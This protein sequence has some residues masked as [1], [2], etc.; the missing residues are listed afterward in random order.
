MFVYRNQYEAKPTEESIKTSHSNTTQHKITIGTS[1]I[2]LRGVFYLF[3]IDVARKILIDQCNLHFYELIL[4]IGNATCKQCISFTLASVKIKNS[5]LYGGVEISVHRPKSIGFVQFSYSSFKTFYIINH[6]T[7]GLVSF[8]FDHCT[9]V[10]IRW[11]GIHLLHAS[12]VNI[13]NCQF[14]F[15][16]DAWCKETS[17]CINVRG[18][19][20]DKFTSNIHVLIKRIF[21][22]LCNFW[23][24]LTVHAENSV[25][26]GSAGNSGG[27]M[28]TCQEINLIMINCRMEMK[29]ISI[30]GLTGG[31]L[32]FRGR[33]YSM[34]GTNVTFDAS[35]ASMLASLMVI[36]AAK[37][38][39]SNVLLL[40]GKATSAIEKAMAAGLYV[41]HEYHCDNPCTGNEYTFE[42]GSMVLQGKSVLGNFSNLSLMSIRPNCNPCPIGANCT[43]NI[44]ALP[45]YWGYKDKSD[46]VM[47]IR[48]PNGYCCQNDEMC[49]G[50]DSCN[51]HRTGPLCAKC[52]GNWTESLFSPECLPIEYCPAGEIIALY[53]A[54]VVAYGLGLIAFSYV[55]DLGP[56]V[57][58]KIFETFKRKHKKREKQ[59]PIDTCEIEELEP[60][61]PS[62]TMCRSDRE[63][64]MKLKLLKGKQDSAK[65]IVAENSKLS[66]HKIQIEKDDDVMKYVQ[67]LFYYVQDAVLFKV[68][69]P[70]EGHQD[71]SIV[72]K[73][74]HF[75]PEVVTTLYTQVSSLCFHPGT[76]AVTKILFS[77]LFG[78]CVIVFIL[79]LY[80][81][82]KYFYH[83]K[84]KSLKMF[85]A[86]LVQ[87]FLLVVLFSYQNM[88]KGTFALVQCV[89]IENNTVLYVQG[90]IECHSY[91]QH[92]VT[93]YICLSIIPVFLVLSHAPFCVEDKE[94]SVRTFILGCLLP[95]PVILVYYMQIL[96]TRRKERLPL[97]LVPKIEVETSSFSEHNIIS[98]QYQTHDKKNEFLGNGAG[99]DTSRD[100]LGQVYSSPDSDTDIG[101]EYS[102]DFMRGNEESLPCAELDLKETTKKG[103]DTETNGTKNKFSDC[104]EAINHTLLKH[105]RPLKVCSFRF[106]WLGIHKLYRVSLVA[107]NT[108]ITDPLKKLCTMSLVL[109]IIATVNTFTKPYNDSNTNRVAI[110]SY[111]ANICIAFINLCKTML[112]T[113]GCQINCQLH[114][115]TA[116]WYLDK[117]ENVLLIY[118][119]LV[120]F[121]TALLYLAAQKCRNKE[122]D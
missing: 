113:Y 95:L 13:T 74:L 96:V 26:I 93:A 63:L 101:S 88:V 44:Q 77:S 89:Q 7:R 66:T 97:N 30:P 29:E 51:Q 79:F 34:S 37:I 104:R 86:R 21:F 118:V 32:D 120:L 54:C 43:K 92:F 73:I 55:K 45:N 38:D 47:M 106:T 15:R 46:R 119:P 82:Q 23:H 71:E 19:I 100:T 2:K 8:H 33:I 103:K 50:I 65:E 78:P 105:Y 48:C 39:F 14:R 41:H 121:P 94:M 40:C 112:L 90:D 69:L 10:D 83:R 62:K 20:G 5:T 31:F 49:K 61:N 108:Y 117:V 16:D 114:R 72:V 67:I 53:I 18:I 75:S 58:K 116:L 12:L 42:A 57:V 11:L 110:L 98:E 35:N 59:V 115:D 25:F 9:L 28:I 102:I 91:W 56:S 99:S 87:I 76:T 111:T 107:C 109:M 1:Q 80:L 85:R 64:N 27:G 52:Q 84:P 6:A 81:A 4:H 17:G 70:I 3:V 122:R 68:R 24:C 22:P 36:N 60:E